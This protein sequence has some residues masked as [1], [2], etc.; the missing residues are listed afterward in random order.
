MCQKL[1]RLSHQS[2]I[3]DVPTGWTRV[4]NK[5]CHNTTGSITL[6]SI[7]RKKILHDEVSR[8]SR[9][10]NTPLAQFLIKLSTPYWVFLNILWQTPWEWFTTFVA[11]KYTWTSRKWQGCSKTDR[12]MNHECTLLNLKIWSLPLIVR[13]E[14]HSCMTYWI[15]PSS[16]FCTLN[17]IPKLHCICGAISSSETGLVILFPTQIFCG[18]SNRRK[19]SI[20]FQIRVIVFSLLLFIHKCESLMICELLFSLSSV[21]V[22]TKRGRNLFLFSQHCT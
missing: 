20:V 17:T 22:L 12:E 6:M 14:V 2:E 1:L 19:I 16:H 4:Y 7:H 15:L 11:V 18:D 10:C 9:L 13:N 3:S 21:T 8:K 5:R